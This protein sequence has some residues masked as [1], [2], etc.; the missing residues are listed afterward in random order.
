[1]D[2]DR[3][4]EQ[5]AR[6]VLQAMGRRVHATPPPLPSH[7]DPAFLNT[8]PDVKA[9]A[10]GLEGRRSARLACMAYWGTGKLHSR[11]TSRKPWTDPLHLKRGSDL[12]SMWLGGNREEHRARLRGFARGR[13]AVADRRGGQLPA[14]PQRCPAQLGGEPGQRDAD[15][16]GRLTTA[17]SSPPRT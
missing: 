16:D 13:G 5:A 7:Y 8:K 1:M 11:T 9:L 6:L 15:R 2:R 10:K 14:G 12:Q 17:S 3:E 4:A